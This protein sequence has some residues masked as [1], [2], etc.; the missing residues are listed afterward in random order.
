[1]QKWLLDAA[2]TEL[3]GARKINWIA[4]SAEQENSKINQGGL[5][6]KIN[7]GG[8]SNSHVGQTHLAP[9]LPVV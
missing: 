7:P 9:D 3:E 2:Q 5:T 8:Q 4:K 6:S 1:M